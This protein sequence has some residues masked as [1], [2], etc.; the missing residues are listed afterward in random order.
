MKSYDIMK[1]IPVDY[2]APVC[3]AIEL[4]AESPL[5]G[6]SFDNIPIN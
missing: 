2:S 3:E 5:M 4:V 6:T 1:N